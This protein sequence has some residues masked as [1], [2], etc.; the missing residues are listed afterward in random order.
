[1]SQSTEATNIRPD[2]GLKLSRTELITQAR[3]LACEQVENAC[4]PATCIE[5]ALKAKSSESAIR[6]LARDTL[7]RAHLKLLEE[8]T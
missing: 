4:V 1:M 7:Y 3:R 6:S 2:A 5:D 8:R